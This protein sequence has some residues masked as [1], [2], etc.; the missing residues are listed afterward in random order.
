[1]NL[2]YCNL[3]KIVSS[4]EFSKSANLKVYKQEELY[5]I[6]YNKEKLNYNNYE[7]LLKFRSVI[8]DGKT[9]YSVAPTKSQNLYDFMKSNKFE[10]CV[11]EE[12]IEGTMINCFYH[13]D[14]WKL[15]TRSRIHA[16]CKFNQLASKTFAEMFH[17]A[18]SLCNLHFSDLHKNYMYTFVLQHPENRIVVEFLKPTI[19]LVEMK[20][21]NG[22]IMKMI[23]IHNK[24]FDYLRDIVIFPKILHYYNSWDNLLQ[25]M[26][27]PDLHYTILGC[28]IKCKKTGR[29]AKIRNPTYEKVR[30]LRGNNPKI[31]F[32]YYN[33]RKMGKVRDYLYYFPEQSTEFQKL[34]ED[35]HY[36]TLQL[37][38]YYVMCY[39]KK[40]QS[41]L[42]LYPFQFRIHM[43]NLHQKYLTELRNMGYY[44]SKQVVIKYVNNLAPAALMYSVNYY[45]RHQ[46][47]DAP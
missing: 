18:M 25:A 24:E 42:K 6:R 16:N 35:L 2:E 21:Y 15:A 4:T 20:E 38:D 5:V 23:D 34:R 22:S 17:E 32:Q 44:V 1:M 47:T 29:R 41:D 19:V 36:W 45:L 43:Y 28:M 27:Q 3:D 9:V 30:H 12:F 7:N 11:I 26:T 46:V 14:E 10:D 37:Y 31:Q 39:I 40:E 8:T 33:L 13:N